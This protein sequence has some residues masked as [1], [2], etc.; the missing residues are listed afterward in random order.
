M[1]SR[2]LLTA[3][4][5][6]LALHGLRLLLPS[7]VPGALGFSPILAAALVAGATCGG[8]A[9]ALLLTLALTAAGD[10]S[11][12]HLV[13]HDVHGFPIYPGWEWVYGAIALAV[14]AGRALAGDRFSWRKF[15]GLS[16][17]VTLVHWLFADLGVWVAGGC[18]ADCI[19]EYTRD[20]AGFVAV[21]RAALPVE[22]RLLAATAL[23][24]GAAFAIHAAVV[25]DHSPK[26]LEAPRS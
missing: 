18:G 13:Y 7:L 21:M 10:L 22:G 17:T 16:A 24:G 8:L 6:V 12:Q 25:R 26:P 2:R 4:T 9:P 20:T 19:R 14:V 3:L 23:F 5:L 15:A 1:T 11:V